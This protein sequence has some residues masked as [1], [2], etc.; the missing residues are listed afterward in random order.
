M[1]EISK[2][3][4]HLKELYK[5]KAKE[6]KQLTNMDKQKYYLDIINTS[7]NKIKTIC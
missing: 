7:T 3:Y 1:L 5:Q 4:P 6:H 2:V